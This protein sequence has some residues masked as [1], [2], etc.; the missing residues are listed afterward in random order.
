[1]EAEKAWDQG[2]KMERGLWMRKKVERYAQVKEWSFDDTL[3]ASE[4]ALWTT[5]G[6]FE[7][8]RWEMKCVVRTEK[9]SSDMVPREVYEPSESGKTQEVQWSKQMSRCSGEAAEFVGT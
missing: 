2:E 3:V 7:G 8:S 1:M 5:K 9:D 4:E 6:T